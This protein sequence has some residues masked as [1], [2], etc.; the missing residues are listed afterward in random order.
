[1]L[2]PVQIYLSLRI[3]HQIVDNWA[4]GGDQALVLLTAETLERRADV[5]SDGPLSQSSS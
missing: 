2:N 1:M 3:F 4:D 5:G